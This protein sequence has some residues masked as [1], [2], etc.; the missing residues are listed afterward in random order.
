MNLTM[1]QK[2]IY[3]MEKFAGGAISIVCGSMLINTD[4]SVEEMKAT[5]QPGDMEYFKQVATMNKVV[6]F[7]KTCVK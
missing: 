1:P 5:F 2:L 4:K 6:A 7:L 3:D